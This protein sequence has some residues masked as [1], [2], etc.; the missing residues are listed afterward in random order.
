MGFLLSHQIRKLTKTEA[1]IKETV[2]KLANADIECVEDLEGLAI[3]LQDRSAFK[4]FLIE[5]AGI[6]SVTSMRITQRLFEK[7][8]LAAKSVN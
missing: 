1:K 7:Q 3:E 2:D 5:E 8:A 4:K 6:P